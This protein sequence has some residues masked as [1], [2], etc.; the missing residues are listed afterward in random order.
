MSN[1]QSSERAASD[2]LD[3]QDIRTALRQAFAECG[4]DNYDEDAMLAIVKSG[5]RFDEMM[6][7]YWRR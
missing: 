7:D 4:V 1:R 6:L 2:D 5:I 3:T